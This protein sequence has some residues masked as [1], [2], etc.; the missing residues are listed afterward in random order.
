MISSFSVLQI[1]NSANKISNSF[2][3]FANIKKEKQEKARTIITVMGMELDSMKMEARL[4]RGQ[5][6]DTSYLS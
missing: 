5:I 3:N 1:P 2:C 4:P 6:G